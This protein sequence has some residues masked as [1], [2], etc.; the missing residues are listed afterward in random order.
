[1]SELFFYI[2]HF[3]LK[4]LFIID[5]KNSW[6]QFFRYFFVGAIAAIVNI[7]MLYVFTD[8]FHIYY[9]VSN[10]LSFLLGLLV[11]YF[12]SKK[13]VFQETTTIS[14]TKEFIIYAMIGVL[15][16]SIDTLLIKILTA[17]LK[18][19]YMISKII[20]TMIVFIWNFL[21]RKILYLV[22]K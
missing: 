15:G 18:I 7:G 11:N 13:F 17:N 8:L 9:L 12:L 3:K 19:Y 20:S 5:T 16:L 10:V 4:E 21:A 14:K 2:F 22:I 1:M 6:I